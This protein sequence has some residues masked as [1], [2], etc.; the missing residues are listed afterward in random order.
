[1]RYKLIIEACIGD[2]ET[3][4]LDKDYLK[5]FEKFCYYD[6]LDL[7]KDKIY[8]NE[9]YIFSAI[10]KENKDANYISLD[11]VETETG[12][13]YSVDSRQFEYIDGQ[14]YEM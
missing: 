11:I 6:D 4:V 8:E 7:C 2:N 14:F 13:V 1:M 9:N 10:L 5:K 12:D 3:E